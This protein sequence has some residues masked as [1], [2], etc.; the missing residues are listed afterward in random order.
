MIPL[1]S[2][3]KPNGI[4]FDER[5]LP[6]LTAYFSEQAVYCEEWIAATGTIT[7]IS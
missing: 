7:L 1:E 2:Y 4:L 3:H 6:H 5:L